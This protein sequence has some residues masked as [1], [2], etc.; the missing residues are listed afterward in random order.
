MEL[1]AIAS[2]IVILILCGFLAFLIVKIKELMEVEKNYAIMTKNYSTVTILQEIMVILGAKIQASQKLERINEILINRF[3]IAYSSIVEYTEKGDNIIKAS[4]V[5]PEFDSEVVGLDKL[6]EFADSMKQDVPKYITR[7]K[8]LEYSTAD[9]RN[10]R[11]VLMFPLYREDEYRGFWVL[12]DIRSNAFDSVKV[13]L[14]IIKDN[15]TL[16]LQNNDYAVNLENKTSELEVAN[17]KLEEMANRDGLTGAFNKA[18]MHKVLDGVFN[19]NRRT[20][21]LAIMDID[22]FKNYNDKNGHM[23]GDNLLRTLSQLMTDSLRDSDMLFRFGG[24]EF[25]ILF[26]ETAKE[27][28]IMVAERIRQKVADFIFPFEEKQPSG[29][30]TISVGV[31]FAPADSTEKQRILEIADERLYKA[32]SSGRNKVVWE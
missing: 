9:E 7:I 19:G 8:T 21:S 30:L 1:V 32:K 27:D 11:S 15:I 17:K 26:S 24:E 14:S 22:H 3:D 20:N 18:F 12:E 31:A 29:D 5:P 13:Q 2:L 10:I 25:V 4:N 28:A 6:P 23:E 16:V